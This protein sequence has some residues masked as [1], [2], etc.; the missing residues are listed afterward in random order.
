MRKLRMHSRVGLDRLFG[1]YHAA[2]DLISPRR[3]KHILTGDG[4]FSRWWNNKPGGGHLW[5]GLNGKTPFPK[6]WTVEDIKRYVSDVATDPNSVVFGAPNSGSMYTHAGDPVRIR[7][8]G[9]RD[10]V[11]IKV[12][13]E[14]A[15]EGIITAYPFPGVPA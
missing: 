2:E 5:P 13:L 14:P 4:T 6:H 15:G 7:V 8:F 11:Q 10:G 1:R 12:V 3:L 9:T